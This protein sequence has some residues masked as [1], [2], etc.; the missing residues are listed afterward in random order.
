MVDFSSEKYSGSAGH[1]NGYLCSDIG[2]AICVL[3]EVLLPS[4]GGMTQ[5]KGGGDGKPENTKE[6]PRNKLKALATC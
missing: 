3:V 5:G 2:M 6:W 4:R 1:R